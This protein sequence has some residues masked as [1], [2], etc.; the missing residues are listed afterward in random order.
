MADRLGA[1]LFFRGEGAM[2]PWSAMFKEHLATA[3]EVEGVDPHLLRKQR[4]AVAERPA[5][6][7]LRWMCAQALG[8]PYGPFTVWARR[9]KDPL[10]DARFQAR[11]D[12]A[13]NG[14]RLWLEGET[15]AVIEVRCQAAD[16]SRAVGLFATLA[17]TDLVMA[18]GAAAAMPDANGQARLVVRCSGATSALLVNGRNP[19]VRIVPLRRIVDGGGWEPV[20]IVGLPVD[21]PWAGTGYDASPQGLVTDLTDPRDAAVRRLLRGA[22]PI[23]WFPATESARAAP[24]WE[25]ADPDALVEEV[26]KDLLPRI[27]ELYRPGLTPMETAA[28]RRAFAVDPPQQG[29]KVSSLP[30]TAELPPF[31]LLGLPAG[32]DPFLALATGFGTAY[33]LENED[34]VRVGGPDFLVTAYYPRTPFSGEV[35]LAAFIPAPGVHGLVASP[36]GLL[37]GRSGLVQP[38][39]RD[40]PWRETVKV[41]WNRPQATAALGRSTGTAL[42]RF[43]APAAGAPAESLLPARASGGWRPLLPGPDG[44]EGSPG[45]SRSA[46]VDAAA[47]IPLGSGGRSVGYAVAVEDVFGVWSRW[48]DALYTGNEP[49]PPAPRVISVRLDSTFAGTSTCPATL[50]VE[51][52]VDWADRTPAR[53]DLAANFYRMPTL[54]TPPPLVPPP[55]PIPPGGF[56]R[57]IVLNVSGD[58]LSGPAGVTVHALDEAGESVV[59]PGPLQG[60]QGR[61]YRVTATVPS[62]DFG[63][64][65]RWGVEVW[66]RQSV[67]VLPGTGPWTPDLAHPALASAASPVPV[68]PLPPPPLPGVPLGSTPDAQGR[69]H[70]RIAWSLPAGP[71]PQSVVVWEASETAVRQA[72]GL[73][74]RAAEGTVPGQRLVDLRAAYDGLSPTRRRSVFRELLRLPGSAR[75]TDTVLPK[76]S[77]DIH[78]YA[79]TTVTPGG[80]DSGWP[81]GP[82]PH[83]LLRAF[84]APRV[85]SPAA[86]RV[87]AQVGGAGA[88][89]LTVTAGS[90]VPVATF[91]LYRTRSANAARA[92]TTMGPPFATV[93]AVAPPPGTAPDPETGELAYS[94]TWSGPFPASWDDWFVRAVAV[95]VDTVPVEAVRGQRS[96]AS[97]AIT[98]PVLPS[99]GP[100]LAPLVAE[101]WGA[102]DRGVVVRTSTSAPE[103]VTA[104]GPHRLRCVAAGVAA[105]A[106]PLGDVALDPSTPPPSAPAPGAAP[107]T[108]R[109][110]RA[111]GSTPLAVWFQRVDA[112]QPVD[113]EV[114]LADPLGRVTT[115]TLTVAGVTPPPPVAL[116]LVDAFRIAGRGVVVQLRSPAPVDT[117]PPWRLHILAATGV[118]PLGRRVQATFDLP[119]IPVGPQPFGRDAAIQAAREPGRPPFVYSV[120]VRL[121]GRV[122]VTATLISPDNRTTQVS[123]RV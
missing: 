115:R 49:P 83:E 91:S 114:S 66:A 54:T 38:E 28:L 86:P 14:L 100:D 68:L 84:M 56:A 50:V 67:A 101:V 74:Q 63:A 42:A 41:S 75:S 10:D 116:E 21:Q 117:D 52:A 55:A 79:V 69:S 23:G 15:A 48:E 103:K 73:S 112:T 6:V 61:R 104:F 43:D 22:P 99:T 120:L 87:K 24:V 121:Q 113:V 122:A 119:D 33:R 57:G 53:V 16:P 106:Q 8:V 95:P 58:T 35:E 105:P 89:T 88:V 110:A 71:D 2:I 59:A 18:V 108:V 40:R 123:V 27:E 9:D 118:G 72:A 39:T 5:E 7:H 60:D 111:G 36:S 109:L 90:R 47:V 76:G 97:G 70:A 65:G 4:A 96:L 32:A 85:V 94:A 11:P 17:G 20:E 37:A 102:D 81:T 92:V 1:P 12:P 93:A 34:R 78:L 25:A 51:I 64:T 80:A 31:A 13:G 26:R 107:L 98:V 30:A 3:A 77:T 19:S 82:V 46:V 44:P 62:L 29:S 45:F